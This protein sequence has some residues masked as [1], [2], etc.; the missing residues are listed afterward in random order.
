MTERTIP[1]A[2]NEL[3]QKAREL[4]SA[5]DYEAAIETLKQAQELAP[6][7]PYPTYD[8]AFTYLL[9]KDYPKARELYRKTLELSPD[10]FFTAITAL[11]TLDREAE[12]ELPEGTYAAYMMI[13]W[14]QEPE[15]KIGLI[16]QLHQKFPSFA[17]I[18]KEFALLIEEPADRLVALEQGLAADPDRET[19]GI[20]LL[21]KAFVLRAQDESEAA[22]AI[23]DD[24][25]DDPS[26]TAANR[27]LAETFGREN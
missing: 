21:N 22:Q 9:M 17:P 4:G 25:L 13:E 14:V 15:Q 16:M 1:D 10:G 24:L 8:M 23:I 3:H 5:G 7:W 2:A 18:W 6:W 20:L 27:G 11:H 26:T 12:G 19:K